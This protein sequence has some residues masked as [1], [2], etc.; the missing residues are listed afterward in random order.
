MEAK[1]TKGP[2]KASDPR[3]SSNFGGYVSHI[4]AQGVPA[5]LAKVSGGPYDDK[6]VCRA[7]SHLFAAATELYARLDAIAAALENG[8]TVTIEPGSVWAAQ[9]A[10]AL[11]RARG[12]NLPE[13]A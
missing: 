1:F 7:N 4:T 3:K 9:I 5:T 10:T 11:A 12:E 6:D 2:M 13:A 8:E